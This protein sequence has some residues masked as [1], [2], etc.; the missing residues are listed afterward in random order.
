MVSIY[1]YMERRNSAT[2]DIVGLSTDEKPIDKFEN[3]PIIN[4]SVFLE[5]DTGDI[6]LYDEEN[7]KWH[8]M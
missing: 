2:L 3:T 7:A 1:S 5:M 8:K 4:G 6:Y